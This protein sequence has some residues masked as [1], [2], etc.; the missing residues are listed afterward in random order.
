MITDNDALSIY[1][2]RIESR[3]LHPV[4]KHPEIAAEV[5]AALEAPTLADAVVAL[6]DASWGEPLWSAEV[7]RGEKAGRAECP[8]CGGEVPLLT[9]SEG[10]K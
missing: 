8:H 7:L 4:D 9:T 1:D 10:K 5:R 3:H 2:E 6:T